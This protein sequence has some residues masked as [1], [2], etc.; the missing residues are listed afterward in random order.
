MN[1]ASAP[2]LITPPTMFAAGPLGGVLRV[3]DGDD[4]DAEPPPSGAEVI[5]ARRFITDPGTISDQAVWIDCAD[6]RPHSLGYYAA[7]VA[8]A[9]GMGASPSL[10]SLV[11]TPRRSRLRPRGAVGVLVEPASVLAPS[12]PAAIEAIVDAIG[13]AGLA[14]RLLSVDT[15]ER[16]R[17]LQALIVRAT[18]SASGDVMSFVRRADAMGIAV[19]EPPEVIVRCCD[20][21]FQAECFA[22][23]G[24]PTPRTLVVC[25]DEAD[26]V[27]RALGYPCVLKL[28]DSSGARDVHRVDDRAGLVATL[29][30]LGQQSAALIAQ[31]WTPSAFDW[32]IGVLDGELIFAS[33]YDMMPGH[34]QVHLWR[35]GEM[36]GAGP[37][38]AV[39][40]DEVPPAV[41]DAALRAA[42]AVGGGLLGVDVKEIKGA[43]L[44]IEVNDTPTIFRHEEDAIIGPVLYDR[45]V[46]AV[47]RR[48]GAPR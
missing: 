20:K 29:A 25:P 48:V 4:D 13:R 26:R 3:V 17:G 12:D 44:V 8:E 35:D 1:P 16:L 23:H 24:V 21:V 45:L 9:R 34:W 36:L 19:L 43:A 5:S 31:A 18:T 14:A 38:R 27:E 7:V 40:L 32:R 41:L 11:A 15:P 42:L 33:R 22:A 2:R 28:P 37:D 10:R 47:M 39:P 6:M 30:R 46:A